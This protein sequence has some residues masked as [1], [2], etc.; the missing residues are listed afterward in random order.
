MTQLWAWEY[1][2]KTE[3]GV[4]IDKKQS[5]DFYSH[6]TA[7]GSRTRYGNSITNL[8]KVKV[9]DEDAVTK[10]YLTTDQFIK[11]Y[12]SVSDEKLRELGKAWDA[13]Y[14]AAYSAARNAAWS[15]VWDAAS[16]ADWD[17]DL[18]VLAKDKITAEQFEILTSPWT[19]CGLSL[20]AEDWDEVLNPPVLEPKGFGAVVEAF[21]KT[22]KVETHSRFTHIGEGLWVEEGTPRKSYYFD[23]LTNPVVI[24][25][26][27]K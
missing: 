1:E 22:E 24:S 7:D 3:V 27:Q 10:T 14:S 15:A 2:G 25:E 5:E 6:R 17:T 8:R 19:S 20:Y 9:V 21:S 26:G 16:D 23:E 12:K 18:A 13:A 4:R 11:V